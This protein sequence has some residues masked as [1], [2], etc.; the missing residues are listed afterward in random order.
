V[1]R[2]CSSRPA[3]AVA[4][5]SCPAG[6]AALAARLPVGDVPLVGRVQNDRLLDTRTLE[7]RGIHRE[8]QV[9]RAAIG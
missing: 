7:R 2:H 4:L 5:D 6:A 9:M 1:R 3:G 8:A